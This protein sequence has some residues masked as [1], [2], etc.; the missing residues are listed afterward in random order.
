[1]LLETHLTTKVDFFQFQERN[2]HQTTNRFEICTYYSLRHTPLVLN[3]HC[4]YLLQNIHQFFLIVYFS[5][6]HEQ[7]GSYF[8]RI[9]ESFNALGNLD[10]ENIVKDKYLMHYWDQLYAHVHY[11]PE[12]IS[13]EGPETLRIYERIFRQTEEPYNS[14]GNSVKDFLMYT[15]YLNIAKYMHAFK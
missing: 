10:A 4:I 6:H 11:V 3:G 2:S 5:S 15:Y 12:W 1:M 14:S 8:G 7:M 9:I 13:Y